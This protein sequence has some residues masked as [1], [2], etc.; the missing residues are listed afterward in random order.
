MATVKLKKELVLIDF[1]KNLFR[2]YNVEVIALQYNDL[3]VIFHSGKLG[4]KGQ[5][6]VQ[7]TSDYKHA[8]SLAYKKIVEKKAEN[9]M[10]LEHMKAWLGQ[11]EVVPIK[12]KAEKKPK[13][14]YQ[15]QPEEIPCSSCNNPIKRE[16]YNKIDE[17]ARGQGNWD[18]D[19]NFV[20]YEKVLCIDCQFKYDIFKKRM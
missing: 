9:F 5:Q 1:K 11:T 12:P 10:N 17:W 13:K 4:N 16:I 18:K 8:M 15:N 2:F 7:R 6:T 3:Q 14:K 20:G 19:I